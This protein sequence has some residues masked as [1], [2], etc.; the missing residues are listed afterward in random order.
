[1]NT[2]PTVLI[3]GATSGIGLE[4]ARLYQGYDLYLL[5][6]KPLSD[7]DPV[8]FD[9]EHYCQTDLAKPAEAA[10]ALRAFLAA[11][12]VERLDLLIH[13]AGRGYYAPPDAQDDA[14]VRELV[15]VNLQAPIALT[16]ALLPLL[17]KVHGKVA[18]ISSV[19]ASLPVP[20]YAAYGAS[21]AGID[22][23]AR[24]LS[25]ELEDEV[26][27]QIVH[28][29][30]TRSEMHE[31][32]GVPEEGVKM[33]DTQEVAQQIARALESDRFSVAI[34]TSNTLIHVAGKHARTPVDWY[35][36]RWRR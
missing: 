10:E 14:Q 8:L 6:R 19:A 25:V 13:N 24:S 3:T 29:G 21:K 16:Q 5:G 15:A 32:S 26:R 11:R 2:P 33:A 30:P 36:R 35:V 4:L 23:F 1:M 28:P 9:A 27:V 18:F 34:G 22:A 17:K 31:K 20:N 7:L 12:K